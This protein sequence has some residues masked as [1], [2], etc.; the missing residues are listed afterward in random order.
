MLD[1]IHGVK[2]LILKNISFLNQL[3]H[4]VFFFSLHWLYME[5]SGLHDGKV[6]A[7]FGAQ[8]VFVAQV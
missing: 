3:L 2:V 5:T 7:H 8:H 6:F 1:L 4:V